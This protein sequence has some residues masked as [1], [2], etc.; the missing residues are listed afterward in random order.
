MAGAFGLALAVAVMSVAPAA[1][2][3][4]GIGLRLLNVPAGARL[5]PR[6]RIYIVDHLAPGT[7]IHRRIEI[8]NT[9]TSSAHVVM[10]PGAATIAKGAFL[11]AAGHTRNDL[12]TWSSI[13]PGASDVSANTRATAVVTIAVPHDAAPGERYGVVWAEVRS[14]PPAGGGITQIN[15]VGIRI[16]LS[17]GAGAAPAPNF[18]IKSLTGQR[19]D[20]GRPLVIASVHNIGGRVLD[21]SGTLR[22]R[23]GPGGLSAGP[24]PA[25]LGTTLGIGDTEPVTILLD[26]RL[27]AGRWIARVTLRS[28]LVQR[29]KQTTITFPRSRPASSRRPFAILA[30]LVSLLGMAALLLMFRG[31][32]RVSRRVRRPWRHGPSS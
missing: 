17:V 16:Y 5:D 10:Y 26:K 1:A 12:S 24:F 28:G 13:R 11:V 19:S 6:A 27:P 29:S 9:T 30:V 15:R 22:L 20:D 2:S 25:S 23:A 4:G 18:T 32:P 7:V 3:T 14:S 31:R 8:S 21:L